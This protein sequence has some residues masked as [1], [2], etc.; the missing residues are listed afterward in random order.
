MVNVEQRTNRPI[1]RIACVCLVAAAS[2]SSAL[3]ASQAEIDA[4]VGGLLQL[5]EANNIYAFN[6]PVLVEE[7]AVGIK[8]PAGTDSI[9]WVSQDPGFTVIAPPGRPDCPIAL[10]IDDFDVLMEYLAGQGEVTLLHSR[11]WTVLNNNASFVYSGSPPAPRTVKARSGNTSTSAIRRDGSTRLT[12]N[13]RGIDGSA[14]AG[15]G[16]KVLDFDLTLDMNYVSNEGE[17]GPA[18][19]YKTLNVDSRSKL[20]T[21]HTMLIEDVHGDEAVLFLLTLTLIGR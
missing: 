9:E 10:H 16:E 4:Y 14:P 13:I 12:L 6:A 2:A 3:A 20:V 17:P 19:G 1:V 7:T 18:S 5:Y 21:G 11:R 8:L 15:T